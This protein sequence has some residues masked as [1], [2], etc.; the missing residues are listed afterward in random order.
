MKTIQIRNSD[1]VIIVADEH[2]ER[3]SIFKWYL[4]DRC[5]FRTEYTD[6]VNHWGNFITK[7]I[8]IQ[9]TVMERYDI[10]FDH[11]DRDIFNNLPD[12]I[13]ECTRN[14]NMANRGKCKTKKSSIY[15]GVSWQ[16]LVGKWKVQIRVNGKLIY[17]GLFTDELAA[18]KRYDEAAIKYHGEFAQLNFPVASV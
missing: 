10:T 16:M 14:Q 17:L 6:R 3:L 13:R 2:F 15:K 5:I 8:S 18:A 1:K 9:N 11:K 7:S 12:N 4:G